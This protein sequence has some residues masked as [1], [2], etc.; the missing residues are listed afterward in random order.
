[1]S[2]SVKVLADFLACPQCSGFPIVFQH[3]RDSGGFFF[4]KSCGRSYRVENGVPDFLPQQVSDLP[5]PDREKWQEHLDNFVRWRR[6]TWNGSS[7]AEKLRRKADLLS[8]R[9]VDFCRISETH[10]AILDIGCGSGAVRRYL[11]DGSIYIGIDPLASPSDFLIVRGTGE[12][13][14]FRDRAFDAVLVM[15]TADHCGSFSLL[16][17]E[18][19]RV[20]APGG[21]ICIM[22]SVVGNKNIFLRALNKIRWILEKHRESPHKECN[23]KVVVLAKNDILRELQ[24]RFINIRLRNLPGRIFATAEKETDE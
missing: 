6:L 13:L 20:L 22:Q 19:K 3:N 17:E 10:G 21:K 8:R 12:R 15:E 14:P 9:F 4:C 5:F 7:G 24:G 16:L 18:A 11:P 1:M 23:C 2:E